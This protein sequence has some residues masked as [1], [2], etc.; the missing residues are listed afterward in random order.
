MISPITTITLRDDYIN[1]THISVYVKISD[2]GDLVIDGGDCGKAPLEFWGDSDYEYITTIKK[3]Y[4][5][6]VLLLL[7]KDKF[8]DSDDFREWLKAKDIPNEYFTWI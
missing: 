5:D 2:N 4:K 8:K 3:E 1:D 7:V 6:T